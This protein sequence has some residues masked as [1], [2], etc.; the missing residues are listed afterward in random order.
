MVARR[1]SL[2]HPLTG[3]RLCFVSKIELGVG[4]QQ[5]QITNNKE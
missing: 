3:E 5:E 2:E 1:V 4:Q